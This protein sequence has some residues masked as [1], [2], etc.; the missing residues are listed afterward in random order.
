MTSYK[1]M[2]N[3][4]VASALLFGA[5]GPVMARGKMD[6]AREAVAAA[7]AKVEVAA[8]LGASGEVPR[9]QAEAAAALRTAEEDV[10]SSRKDEAIAQ[11]N[12]ASQ[13]ADTAIGISERNRNASANVNA[14]VAVD[15]AQQAAAANA[16]AQAATAQ[17]DD[18]NARA[19]AAER[20]ARAAQDEAAAAR[21]APAPAPT[22]V[23]TTET[24]KTAAVP[25]TRTVVK[26]KPRV[27]KKTVRSTTPVRA[28]T[29]E[30][31]TTTVTTAPN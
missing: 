4:A 16:Q 17:A 31:T 1:T 5:A 3:A 24:T 12:R 19:A 6:R 13:L 28:A 9:L 30:K 23:I 29:T 10:A 7:R 8:K 20:A 11:A 18:A 2:L 15:A 27:V 14:A 25:A 21:A 22:T 26:A